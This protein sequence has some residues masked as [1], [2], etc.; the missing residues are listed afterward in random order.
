MTLIPIIDQ[1]FN[2]L[3]PSQE[4]VNAYLESINRDI[5]ETEIKF[6][7]AVV[8]VP[9]YSDLPFCTPAPKVL[10]WAKFQGKF[11][12]CIA[13]YDVNSLTVIE[14]TERA[15]SDANAQTRILAWEPKHIRALFKAYAISLYRCGAINPFDA[16]DFCTDLMQ[17]DDIEKSQLP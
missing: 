16:D 8:P 1:C 15:L 3:Q 4:Q 12:L 5:R 13:D 7:A 2:K 11:H 9:F 17:D 10:C 14:G 6:R